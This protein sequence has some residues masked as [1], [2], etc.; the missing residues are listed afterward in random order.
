[1][2]FQQSRVRLQKYLSVLLLLLV[3]I[4]VA[5]VAVKGYFNRAA[6]KAGV[7]ESAEAQGVFLSPSA[8]D[9]LVGSSD[10]KVVL[11][12]YFDLDCPYCKDYDRLGEKALRE[13]NKNTS[14][15]FAY[16]HLP[17]RYLHPFALVKAETLECAA[18]QLP[19][20]KKEILSSLYL[21]PFTSTSTLVGAVAKEFTLD[22]TQLQL[23]V[24]SGLQRERV[25]DDMAKAA[26]Q[27]I[28]ST[29]TFVIYKNG[30]ERARV[31]GYY[32]KQVATT[33]DLL[34]KEE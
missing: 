6:N 2:S 28:Y 30:V 3:C 27:G 16:R 4:V 33:I 32:F 8:R 15:A 26:T 1:M 23:C 18:S 20:A 5:G 24:D 12:E 7:A 13:R 11:L 34:L 22:G 9:I 17:L 21:I 25:A 19:S 29:P 14:V 10:A 31:E